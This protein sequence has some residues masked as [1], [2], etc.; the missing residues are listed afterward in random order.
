MAILAV[1]FLDWAG[2]W[3]SRGGNSYGLSLRRKYMLSCHQ[4][5]S[6]N[7]G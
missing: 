2:D 7:N 6:P 5:D 3:R 1:P 4:E